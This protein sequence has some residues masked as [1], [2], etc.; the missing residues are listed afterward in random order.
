[1]GAVSTPRTLA[2][3]DSVEPTTIETDRGE[4]AALSAVP[5]IGTPL[6]TVLLVPGWTGSK[7]DFTPLVAE[8][9]NYGWRA[10]AID[11]RGQYQTPG[12]D[13]PSAYALDELG[14]DVVALSKELGG[15]SQL[16]GHSLGG[17]IAQAA[18]IADPSVFSTLTLLCSGPRGFTAEETRNQL[19][20][21]AFGLENLPI[22]QVYELKLQHDS[23]RPDWVEPP[24]D[25]KQFLRTRFVTNS[26]TGLAQFSRR[27]VDAEDRLDKVERSGVRIQVL[28]GDAD[29]GWTPAVQDDM[30][31]RL[32]VRAQVIAD[33]GHSPAIEQPAATARLLTQFFHD[34]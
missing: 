23:S 13:D 33:S 7:E 22:E 19:E 27:L 1:M 24:A 4:F 29:D 30:A 34:R 9:A 6:G 5:D 12:P 8:L 25:V 11:Q 31:L 20:L 3:P 18:V 26:P 32:G 16:V 28:Y 21:L 14:R 17:L 10:F 15:Y 2:L